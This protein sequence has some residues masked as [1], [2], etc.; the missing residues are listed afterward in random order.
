M[1][2]TGIRRAPV[3]ISAHNAFISVHHIFAAASGKFPQCA[4]DSLGARQIR[5]RNTTHSSPR[6]TNYR[7]AHRNRCL[8]R[9][10]VALRIGPPFDSRQIC[11]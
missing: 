6:T 9:G 10:I 2:W 7:F 8:A 5:L 4:A 3:K 11:R 1:L